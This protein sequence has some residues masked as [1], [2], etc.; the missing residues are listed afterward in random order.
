M[1]VTSEFV[2]Q[3][4]EKEVTAM[5]I[6]CKKFQDSRKEFKS[7]RSL[8]GASLFLALDIVLVFVR[9]DISPS[10]Q[11]GFSFIAVALM[12]M[13]YGPVV[14]GLGAGLGDIIKFALKPAGPYFFG[15]T[16]NAILGGVIYG[17]FLYKN[18][19]K[20][21]NIAAAKT[22]VNILINLVLNTYWLSILYGKAFTVMLIPRVAKNILALPIEIFIL[23]T[24]IKIVNKTRK[25]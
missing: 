2:Q 20:L 7:V 14:A 18:K 10:L 16:L 15:F 12:G 19:E 11:I 24:F 23:Y 9:L 22:S 21:L 8:V 1:R 3:I 4:M 13:M 5:N 25:V 17:I 6:L